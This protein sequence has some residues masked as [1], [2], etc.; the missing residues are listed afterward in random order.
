MWMRLAT[1]GKVNTNLANV[2]TLPLGTF[3]KLALRNEKHLNAHKFTV[4]VNDVKTFEYDHPDAKEYTNMEL[5][6][7]TL[8]S[9]R[10]DVVI[11]NLVYQNLGD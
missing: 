4:H 5:Y 2:G 7:S 3:T 1:N 9:E 11:R 8:L 6:C 10:A